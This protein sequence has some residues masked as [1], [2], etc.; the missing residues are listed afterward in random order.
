M[1]VIR[2]QTSAMLSLLVL[3]MSL[4][5]LLSSLSSSCQLCP[6]ICCCETCFTWN[7]WRLDNE[8]VY[9]SATIDVSW[10]RMDSWRIFSKMLRNAE[11]FW[12]LE[13]LPLVDYWVLHQWSLSEPPCTK[14]VCTTKIYTGVTTIAISRLVRILELTPSALPPT[15]G[16]TD[17]LGYWMWTLLSLPDKEIQE[18]DTTES[19]D[20]HLAPVQVFYSPTSHVRASTHTHMSAHT[21]TRHVTFKHRWCFIH[22]AVDVNEAEWFAGSGRA[23]F[24]SRRKGRKCIPSLATL[25]W[26][27]PLLFQ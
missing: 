6:R 5:F 9:G 23:I 12:H 25:T 1:S 7:Q 16:C 10:L 4:I 18:T 14:L 27:T 20:T 3:I 22:L 21:H 26:N 8:V 15:T 17:H 13:E 19:V 24:L 2:P 11:I